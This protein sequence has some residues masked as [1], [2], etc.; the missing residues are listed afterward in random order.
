ME[1]V[2]SKLFLDLSWGKPHAH[3]LYLTYNKLISYVPLLLLLF[4]TKIYRVMNLNGTN[5]IK[6][7]FEWL[8]LMH[9]L[10]LKSEPNL[11][12]VF[13]V[14]FELTT[15]FLP[16]VV[17]GFTCD[18]PCLGWLGLGTLHFL[19]YSELT[20]M[21]LV[22]NFHTWSLPCVRTRPYLYLILLHRRFWVAWR[23]LF[24]YFLYVIIANN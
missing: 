8:K 23:N 12:L 3:V 10:A 7:G 20:Y 14:C 17:L 11:K 15:T 5:D 21:E 22:P 24:N 9:N 4:Q 6:I 19:W 2:S 13:V 18:L 1:N 16:K